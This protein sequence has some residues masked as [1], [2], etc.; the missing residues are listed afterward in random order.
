MKK[1]LIVFLVIIAVIAGVIWYG[2]G[3][4]GALIKEQMETQGSKYLAIPVSVSNVDLSLSDA[5]LSIQGLSVKNPSGFSDNNAVSLDAVTV[6]LG[7]ATQE[8]YVI[9]EVSVNSPIILY[10]V[11]SSGNGNLLKLKDN[12]M[13]N[14]PKSDTPAEPQQGGANPLVVVENVTVSKVKLMLNFEQLDTGGIP[15]DKKQYEVELPTFNAGSVGKPNG[16][17]AD[18]VGMEIVNKMLDN[19]IA[20][21]KEEAKNQAKDALKQKAK[22][23][24]DEEKAKLE[25]KA[26]NKLKD[27]FNGG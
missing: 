22:E 18:Q 2:I 12:L 13:K 26:K 6:D 21:A 7:G 3:N 11:D 27:L 10:E 14:L 17:P 5:K 9:Q 19:I 25:E 23:K 20:K 15:V 8:P 1:V 16:L 24:L 4:A